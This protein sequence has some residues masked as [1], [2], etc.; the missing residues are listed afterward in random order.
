MINKAIKDRIF[1]RID[2]YV[3][4]MIDLQIKLTAIP[5]LSPDNQGTGEAEKVDFLVKYLMDPVLMRLNK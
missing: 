5:A 3:A 4:D 2:S 1:R